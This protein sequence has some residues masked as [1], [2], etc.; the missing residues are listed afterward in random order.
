[1]NKDQTAEI[2]V[3]LT[4]EQVKRAL[5]AADAD[6]HQ[7]HRKHGLLLPVGRDGELQFEQPDKPSIAAE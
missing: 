4:P 5:A 1:M 3:T 7:E 6:T 2:S